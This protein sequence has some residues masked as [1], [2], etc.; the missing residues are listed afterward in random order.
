MSLLPLPPPEEVASVLTGVRTATELCDRLLTIA[1]PGFG[2]DAEL[3]LYLESDG[4]LWLEATAGVRASVHTVDD[5]HAQ[6]GSEVVDGRRIGRLTGSIAGQRGL[7]VA[8]VAEHDSDD[9]LGAVG[10]LRDLLDRAVATLSD[11]ALEGG[12][13]ARLGRAVVSLAGQVDRDAIV[14]R[15]CRTIGQLLRTECVQGAL[16]TRDELTACATWRFSTRSAR[17]LEPG[18]V[19]SLLAVAGWRLAEAHR[20][21]GSELGR[22]LARRKLGSLVV[23]PLRANGIVVGGIAAFGRRDIE[24]EPDR[25]QQV[26]LVAAQAATAVVSAERHEAAR[27]SHD[28]P[29]TGLPGIRGLHEEG[30]AL[31]A[32]SVASGHPCAV[33]VVD[34]DRLGD[35]SDL[36]GFE[37]ADDVLRRAGAV[38][39]R[40]L[41]PDDRVFGIGGG[42]FAFVLPGTSATNARTVCRRVQRALAALD[43]DGLR[44]TYSVGIAAA[45][46]DGVGL[47]A[48]LMAADHAVADAKCRGGDRIAITRTPAATRPVVERGRR[49]LR[50]L[51]A[52][53]EIDQALA[54]DDHAAVVGAIVDG[55]GARGALLVA[56]SA[57]RPVFAAAGD[58][59]GDVDALEIPLPEE[60]I[61]RVV[62]RP[63]SAF[64]DEDLRFL[65]LVAAR[66]GAAQ[67]LGVV[68]GGA[69]TRTSES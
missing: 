7:L 54:R 68:G 40:G 49:A 56:D 6:D 13:A 14:E 57:A 41:R 33:V 26:E 38:F 4:R 52:L 62:P 1:R 43:L 39:Q 29:V 50:A 65:R 45:P 69:S 59:V 47:R 25:L 3:A 37:H 16:G 48:L 63:G 21:D 27:A 31:L 64:D 46:D 32:A 58:A 34:A 5:A 36:R 22:L 61:L 66:L 35:F 30:A 12:A 18:A 11:R 24:I 2:D 9:L 55:I 8:T 23:I 20:G 28:D 60:R 53:E 51:D 17:P 44:L 15:A 10:E 42:R 67:A 19:R